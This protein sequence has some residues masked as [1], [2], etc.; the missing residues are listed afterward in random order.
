MKFSISS[1]FTLGS[2]LLLATGLTY[3]QKN[4]T[5]RDSNIVMTWE[6]TTISA[7]VDKVM[8][9]S[10]LVTLRGTDGQHWT[11]NVGQDVKLEN[12]KPG[13]LVQVTLFQGQAL[14]VR[15]PTDQDRKQP[16]VVVNEIKPPEGVNTTTG[17]LRQL[18]ALVTVTHIDKSHHM[19]TIE[20]PMGNSYVLQVKN[21]SLMD[22][23]EKGKQFVVIFTEGIA[24]KIEKQQ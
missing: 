14:D 15:E 17:R 19:V 2:I 18:R 8:P 13:D 22:K 4:G 16:L 1:I 20:G 9:D 12:L 24:A 5:E 10:G 11:L 7:T 21:S 6:K 3:G 23:L